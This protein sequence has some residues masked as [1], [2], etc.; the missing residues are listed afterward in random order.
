MTLEELDLDFA[1]KRVVYDSK[2]QFVPDFLN[3]KEY[4]RN[5]SE[6]L[7]NLKLRLKADFEPKKPLT[8]DQPLTPPDLRTFF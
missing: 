4:E 5:L 1:W 6:N 3:L 7:K 2:N 8:I